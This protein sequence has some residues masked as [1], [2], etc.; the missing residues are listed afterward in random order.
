MKIAWRTVTTMI[1]RHECLTSSS[2]SLPSA[3]KVS[4]PISLSQTGCS[5]IL[6]EDCLTGAGVPYLFVDA[7]GRSDNAAEIHLVSILHTPHES[8]RV[9]GAKDL[10]TISQLT[11]EGYARMK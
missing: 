11:W 3:E 10:S 6:P 7:L 4:F 1:R 2:G 9:K 5:S 8:H